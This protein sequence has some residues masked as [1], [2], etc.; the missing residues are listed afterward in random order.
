MRS[1]A[2][3]SWLWPLAALAPASTSQAASS[4]IR[5]VAKVTGPWSARV[6]ITTN[7][8]DGVSLGATFKLVEMKG[9]DPAL[10]TSLHRA[11]VKGGKATFVLDEWKASS[12]IPKGK[13]LIDLE[14][15]SCA[16]VPATLVS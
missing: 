8:P 14:S 7:L 15:P 1:V 6:S 5:A 10:G 16:E 12:T 3:L 4:Q 11:V 9:G 13:Y 2:F